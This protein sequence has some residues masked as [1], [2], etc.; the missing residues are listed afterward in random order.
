MIKVKLVGKENLINKLK[1]KIKEV[2]KDKLKDT[3][4]SLINDLKEA[5]PV[6]T[7]RARDGWELEE[8][9][10]KTSIVNKVEYIDRLNMGY[11]KQA[12]SFFIEKTLLNNPSVKP[13][14]VIVEYN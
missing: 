1:S 4:K 7:G 14:G 8:S 2:S 13:N 10:M 11:S 3:A 9:L 5:T 12:P 6:D